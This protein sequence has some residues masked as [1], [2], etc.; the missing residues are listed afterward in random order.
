MQKAAS[1]LEA[2]FLFIEYKL[3]FFMQLTNFNYSEV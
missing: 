1:V 2:A 3:L